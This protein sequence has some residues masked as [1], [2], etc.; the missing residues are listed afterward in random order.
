MTHLGLVL[1]IACVGISTGVIFAEDVEVANSG[2][3]VRGKIVDTTEAENPIEGVQVKIVAPA[4]DST[5]YTMTTDTNGEFVKTGIP[6]GR[7]LISIYRDGYGGWLSKHVTV[8]NGGDH[9]VPFIMTQKQSILPLQEKQ[10]DRKQDGSKN[11]LQDSDEHWYDYTLMNTKIGYMHIS[12]EKTE[13]QGEQMTRHKSDIVMNLKALGTDLAIEITNIEYVGA[14]LMLRHFLHTSNMSGLKQVEGRIVDGIA[15]IKTTL[16]GETTESE[17]SVPPDTISQSTGVETLLSQEVFKIGD[18]RTFHVFS[19]D[20]MKPV[21]AEIEVVGQETLTYQSEEKQVYVLEGT[22]DMMGGTTIKQWI[23]PDGVNYRTKTL[24][25]GVP[26]VATKTDRETALGDIEEVDLILKTRILPS[27]KRP[28]PKAEKL[29]ADVKLTTGNIAEAVMSTSRQKLALS[30]VESGRLSI[31]IPTIAAENCLEL[32]I[33]ASE[34]E[35]LNTSAYIQASHP[36]IQVK[37]KEILV[38][39]V[40]SWRA[41]ERLCQ[42]VYESITDKNIKGGFGSSLNTLE[43]LTGDCTEHTVLFI[44]LARA[45]GIPS[46]ICSGIVFVNDAF[47]YHF[48]PEVYVGKWV[49]MDPTFGQIIAD[50]SHIQLWGGFFESDTMMEYAE[51]VYRTLN[52]LEI[53]VVE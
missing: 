4:P 11:M 5:K 26:Q 34:R 47:Y 27:G 7:Y 33:Q 38:G 48:W 37:T 31:Q 12:T 42:W 29:V 8:V 3:T 43:S 20:L 6:A 14:D 22:L 15:Y 28:T 23:S 44:A 18:T 35:F 36:D 25:M 21:K 13:Y 40:N 49:Q 51:G 52:R 53:V 2:G 46:R 30:D 10:K 32:P 41:A 19:F 45:A 16:D 39:E 24:L 17:V 50:A 1:I 9:I